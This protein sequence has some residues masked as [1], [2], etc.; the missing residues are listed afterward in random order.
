MKKV[1]FYT[2]LL[3]EFL[4]HLN[5][6]FFFFFFSDLTWDLELAQEAKQTAFKCPLVALVSFNLTMIGS[7]QIGQSIAIK[8]WEQEPRRDFNVEELLV[9][10]S[11]AATRMSGNIISAAVK[12]RTRLGTID[13]HTERITRY[14]FHKTM[15]NENTKRTL[16]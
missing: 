14:L 6:V 2:T 15:I 9:R 4:E 8:I 1:I 5:H 12:L 13:I 16:T 11:A 7:E 3:Q 10:Y